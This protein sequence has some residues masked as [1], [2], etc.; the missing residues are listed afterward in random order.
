MAFFVIDGAP[1]ESVGSVPED[2][3]GWLL[4]V[5][6]NYKRLL[7]ALSCYKIAKGICLKH[8]NKD[9]RVRPRNDQWKGRQR[10]ES[11]LDNGLATTVMPV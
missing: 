1:S 4:Y 8:S 2:A 5:G 7:V 3:I 11:F 6:R 10:A 9:E